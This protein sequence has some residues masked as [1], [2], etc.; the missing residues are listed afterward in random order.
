MN[1]K[2][3]FPRGIMIGE[4]EIEEVVAVLRSKRLT[5]LTGEK[6]H[7]F[8]KKFANY[9]GVRHGIAVS[10]G[11]AA[12]HVALAAAGIGPGDEVIV[13]A[14]SF[15]ATATCV[16]HQNAVPVF[17]DIEL[18]T[19]NIDPD[20]I[21]EAITDRTKAIIPVHLNGHPANMEKILDVANKHDL[22]VIE[23]CAQAPTAAYKGKKVGTFGHIACFSFWEDKL[24]TTGGEG[25]MLITND[26]ELAERAELIRNHGERI[27]PGESRAY[28]HEVLGYNYRM[29]EMQA[30]IGIV[31]LRKL[32]NMINKRIKN[33]EYLT[34]RLN[35]IPGLTP[36]I[37]KDGYR[38]VY[39]KY[40]VKFEPKKFKVSL[41]GFLNALK[42]KGIPA[43]KRYPTPFNLQPLFRKKVGYG[44]TKC[45]FECP[46][47]KG[48]IEYKPGQCPNAEMAGKILFRLPMN[49]ELSEEDLNDIACV[50]EEVA[51]LIKK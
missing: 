3:I 19:Y 18:D 48:T 35:H 30:A 42:K 26:R 11:T 8:E 23:D 34:E 50:V 16:L 49:A 46:W 22:T 28:R 33:A 14:H 41:D 10:S 2:K 47:Y 20:K 39:Y 9:H 15:V 45:P 24:M 12:L 17:V 27:I 36:P 25:G 13:P 43:E 37:V 44:R 4:E 32:E 40:I 51:E 31:Q 5:M 1:R 7:E 38:H 21:E 29:T 6:V